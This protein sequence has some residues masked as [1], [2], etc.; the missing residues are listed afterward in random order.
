L[1]SIA[2]TNY[3]EYTYKFKLGTD[4]LLYQNYV[5]PEDLNPSTKL[6]ID[7]LIPIM[8]IF[9][10][11][12]GG[13]PFKREK[14]GHAQFSW[15]GGQEHQT[16]SSMVNF[17]IGLQAHELAHQW[18][19]DKVT[20][21]SWE[22]IWLNEGFATYLEGLS[23]LYTG[24]TVD[25]ETWKS[26][27]L[28][29]ITSQPGG[30]VLVDDTTDE[31]RIFNGRLSYAKGAFLLHNLRGILGDSAFYTGVRNY[32]TDPA[33]AY[34]YARTRDLKRHLEQSSRRD[35]TEFFNDYFRG[36]GYP[37]YTIT[38][39]QPSNFST[40]NFLIQQT[41]SHPSV[42]FFEN[43][44]PI[45]ITYVGGSKDTVYINNTA[46]NQLFTLPALAQIQTIRYDPEKWVLGKGV[47]RQG[48]TALADVVNPKVY[49]VPNPAYE[50]VRIEGLPQAD[51]EAMVTVLDATGKA[52][53]NGLT[54][55]SVFS[56]RGLPSGSYVVRITQGNFSVNQRLSVKR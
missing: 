1:V 35:L 21:G 4:S 6:Q 37:V 12:F 44:V 47:T 46:N 40:I 16:M 31:N 45:Q 20:L 56:L 2:V 39:S 11:L 50:W 42:D 49:L 18:F 29:G 19:G 26:Q 28:A 10:S 54:G 7:N 34:A 15:G 9:D 17:D 38:Y 22:D 41:S 27:T 5:Y 14:Y 3:Q 48:V 30:S 13:Y 8:R 36:E 53:R 23:R 52:L 55:E 24:R 43:R 51:E 33:L 32:V 25:W